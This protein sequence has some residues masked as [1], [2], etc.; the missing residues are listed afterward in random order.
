[1][2]I[3]TRKE[4]VRKLRVSDSMIQR[5]EKKGLPVVNLGQHTKRYVLEAV[6]EWIEDKN[7]LANDFS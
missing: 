1:M 4:L 6:M 3:L 7:R 5:L 2:Q